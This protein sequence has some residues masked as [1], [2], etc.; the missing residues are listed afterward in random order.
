[1]SSIRNQEKFRLN[2]FRAK[3][4]KN[5][6]AMVGHIG[7]YKFII[8]SKLKPEKLLYSFIQF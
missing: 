2:F 4:P 3:M 5:Y 1:M 8:I 6:D 7:S